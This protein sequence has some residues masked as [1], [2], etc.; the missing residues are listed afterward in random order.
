[1][2]AGLQFRERHFA[3]H[4]QCVRWYH[5]KI[6]REYETFSVNRDEN[7][8]VVANRED[9]ED[10]E[11]FARKLLQMYKYD[12]FH[13]TK[14]ST[15]R[16]YATSID[17]NIYLGKEDIEDGESVMTAEYRPVEYG[18]DYDVVNNPDKFQLYIDGKEIK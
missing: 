18:K 3:H 13:S 4:V 15:D 10:R 12:S 16:G 1:M 11:A 17:M 8:T 6:R 9:I 14:F 7:I 2:P 5:C